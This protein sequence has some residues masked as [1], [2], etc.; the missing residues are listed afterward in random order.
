MA[1]QATSGAERI[2]ELES[3]LAASEA[4]KGELSGAAKRLQLEVISS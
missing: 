1:G 4:E 3:R 2:R